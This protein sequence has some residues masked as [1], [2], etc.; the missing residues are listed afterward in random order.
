MVYRMAI[1][2]RLCVAAKNGPVY[3]VEWNPNCTEFCIVYGCIL[4]CDCLHREHTLAQ[5]LIHDQGTY[6]YMNIQGALTQLSMQRACIDSNVC[7]W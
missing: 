5:L 2:D 4:L 3:S 7:T 1:V 6:I